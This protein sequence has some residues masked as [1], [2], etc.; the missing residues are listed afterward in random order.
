MSRLTVFGH[1]QNGRVV[2]PVKLHK[3]IQ[4]LGL[5]RFKMVISED[6]PKRS[7]NQNAYW[8]GIVVPH[9]L[10]GIR[11]SGH[12]FLSPDCKEHC[13][14]IHQLICDKF[15]PDQPTIVLK[16]G[17][18]FAGTGRTSQLNT[19][20]MTTLIERVREWS[21]EIFGIYIPIPDELIEHE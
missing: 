6:K 17:F 2:L 21:L 20:E 14:L 18:E 16:D 3:M 1:L 19:G 4:D 13:E 11:D 12:G 9:V 10:E 5:Q 15:L 7:T 8:W